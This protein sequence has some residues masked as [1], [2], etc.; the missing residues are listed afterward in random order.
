MNKAI[1][2][3]RDRSRFPDGDF[4]E[5]VIWEVPTPV[6]P[7]R[8]KFK[9]SLAYIVEGQ[10]VIGYD[11]ERGKGDHRHYGKREEAYAFIS[12]ERLLD[13]FI[14]DVEMLRRRQK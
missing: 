1:L 14:A 7:S 4:V 5:L 9:Y 2:R 8:H 13:D 11:N 12:L 6:L 10:R 3:L